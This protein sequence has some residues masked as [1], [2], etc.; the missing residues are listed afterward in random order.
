M[1]F[2]VS[3]I[4]ERLTDSNPLVVKEV[5]H[6]EDKLFKILPIDRQFSLLLSALG[7]GQLGDSKD[8][9]SVS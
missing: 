8:W 9:D 6:L 7:N 5:L 3:S 2:A 1:S 4:I